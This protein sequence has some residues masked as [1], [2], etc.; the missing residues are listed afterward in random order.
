MVD[1]YNDNPQ[2][3]SMTFIRHFHF[4]TSLHKFQDEILLAEALLIG[5][6]FRFLTQSMEKD[7][8][9]LTQTLKQAHIETL[10]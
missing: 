1:S 5:T 7:W 9:G 6:L 3:L 10:K 2:F 8:T 4:L